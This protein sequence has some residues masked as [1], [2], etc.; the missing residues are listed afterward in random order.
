ME[1]EKKSTFRAFASRAKNQY[2]QRK[3]LNFENW[4]NGEP[5]YLA[6]IREPT[7]VITDYFG[8]GIYI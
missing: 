1:E 2:T 8:A 7:T 5:Q 3:L 4:T 6:K